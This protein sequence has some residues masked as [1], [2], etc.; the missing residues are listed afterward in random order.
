[1][2]IKICKNEKDVRLVK[3]SIYSDIAKEDFDSLLE[4]LMKNQS[5]K[6]NKVGYLEY[7]SLPKEFV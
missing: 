5:V 1:M 7:L 3:G 4:I 6:S 2:G